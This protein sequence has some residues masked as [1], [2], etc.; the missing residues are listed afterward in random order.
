M[1]GDLVERSI[2]DTQGFR[3]ASLKDVQDAQ[4]VP[5]AAKYG[6][7]PGLL[8]M[9]DKSK[10]TVLGEGDRAGGYEAVIKALTSD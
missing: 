2:I 9:T 5:G 4:F 7:L 6:D 10:L 1:A 3:F 8:S